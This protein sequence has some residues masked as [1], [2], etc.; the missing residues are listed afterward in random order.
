MAEPW[1]LKVKVTKT[2]I[3]IYTEVLYDLP[4][5]TVMLKILEKSKVT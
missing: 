2:I 5:V 4:V 3:Q 1:I